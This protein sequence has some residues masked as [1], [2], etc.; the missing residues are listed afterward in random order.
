M[1]KSTKRRGRGEGSVFFSAARGFW[2]ARSAGRPRHESTGK[3]KARAMANLSRLLARPRPS[4]LN[5]DPSRTTVR[6]CL[7]GYLMHAAR[8]VHP[9]T[10]RTHATCARAALAP[11]LENVSLAAL[12]K[13]RL[14]GAFDALA[15]EGRA[16]SGVRRCHAVMRAALLLAHEQGV[17]AEPPPRVRLPKVPKRKVG[18]FSPD[19]VR[20]VLAAAPRHRLGVLAALGLLTGARFAELLALRWPD[21]DLGAKTLTIDKALYPV[22]GR[23]WKA[24]GPKSQ[25]GYRTLDLPELALRALRHHRQRWQGDDALPIITT[26]KG[27]SPS[28]GSAWRAWRAILG[29]AEVPRRPFHATRHTFASSL[30]AAG[31]GVTVVAK[32]LGDRLE[33]LISTYSHWLE[34]KQ[35]VAATVDGLFGGRQGGRAGGT[36]ASGRKDGKRPQSQGQRR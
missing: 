28:S 12:T 31:V 2:I 35:S 18:V 24:K 5:F 19:E 29:D 22:A 27:V 13:A 4:G 30:L 9:S 20:R 7:E 36:V 26:A 3:T 14:Q 21:A 16:P 8:H 11:K 10:L 34:P 6:Q 25:R 17:L 15:D 1:P 33:T 23:G 32:C